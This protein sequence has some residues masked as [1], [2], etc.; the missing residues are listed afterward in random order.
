[1]IMSS[2]TGVHLLEAVSKEV[3]SSAI[4]ACINRFSIR[5]VINAHWQIRL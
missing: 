5:I 2:I 1:M 3:D 4:F